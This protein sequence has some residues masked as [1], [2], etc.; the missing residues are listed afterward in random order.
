MIPLNFIS[1]TDIIKTRC[2]RDEDVGLSKAHI[3]LSYLPAVYNDMRF[4]GTKKHVIKKYYIDKVNN[5]LAIP[6]DCLLL[7]AVGYIDN[8]DRIEGMWYNTDI[9]IDLL[10]EN[11]IGCEC[12]N[13][14]NENTMCSSVS[15]FDNIE[16]NIVINGETY[17][18]TTK[19]NILHD[20]RIIKYTNTPTLSDGSG[21]DEEVI[22]IEKEELVCTLDTLP[23]GC[24]A[25]SDNNKKNIKEKVHCGCSNFSS[26]KGSCKTK[27]DNDKHSFNIDFQGRMIV[28]PKNYDKDYVVLKF[29]TAI[30]KSGDYQIP[31]I[32]QEAVLAG[33]KYYYESNNP[34]A[35]PFTRGQN[36]MFHTLYQAEMN[37]LKKRLR[38][39]RY[40]LVMGAMGV[41]KKPLKVN[42]V[43]NSNR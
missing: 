41:V 3:Y 17:I 30:N 36:G 19:I 4:D 27:C 1:A 42:D 28:L 18:K 37:K 13:C 10:F 6:N 24:I 7:M 43:G 5:T 38:P 12:D 23:C 26:N 9:P 33:L 31:A 21:E 40:D 14:S 22:F 11:G 16:E 34:T 2:L 39:L 29:V 20:G 8:C 35:M 25:N 15:S 32:A